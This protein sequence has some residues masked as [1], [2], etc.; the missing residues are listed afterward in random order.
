MNVPAPVSHSNELKQFALGAAH[1]LERT[2]T[3]KDEGVHLPS[4]VP[5]RNA[6]QGVFKIQGVVFV[7]GKA[8]PKGD[9]L[10][11]KPSAIQH[12]QQDRNGLG[13]MDRMALPELLL[14]KGYTVYGLVRRVSTHLR[15]QPH[16]PPDEQRQLPPS[17][18]RF[19]RPE[20][21]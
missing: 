20:F 16:Q 9:R 18:R 3:M 17:Q 13:V 2:R 12:G 14:E 1:G 15:S 11:R 7:F 5:C 4:Q 8:P 21:H 19:G 10:K 6:G